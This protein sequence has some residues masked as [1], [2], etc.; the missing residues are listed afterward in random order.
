MHGQSTSIVYYTEREMT[1]RRIMVMF[2]ICDHSP[3]ALYMKKQREESHDEILSVMTLNTLNNDSN[4]TVL[5][6]RRSLSI[7][8]R[9][10]NDNKFQMRRLRSWRSTRGMRSRRRYV[11]SLHVKGLCFSIL[12]A[13]LATIVFQHQA[14]KRAM[15][16][17]RKIIRRACQDHDV[18]LC[19]KGCIDS[20][21]IH[22]E[23]KPT[24]REFYYRLLGTNFIEFHSTLHSPFQQ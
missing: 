17:H 12:I 14:R 10:M 19:E 16:R 18:W 24:G 1:S 15:D 8:R 4:T 11:A 20:A 22:W 21:K 2:Q 9:N 3:L 23:D 5:I 7:S 6:A 13:V